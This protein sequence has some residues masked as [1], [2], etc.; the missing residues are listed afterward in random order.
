MFLVAFSGH[1]IAAKADPIPSQMTFTTTGSI[2]PTG[3]DGSPIVSFHGV[4]DGTLTTGTP[5]DL[6]TLVVTPPTSGAWPTYANA[7]LQ[8]N[9]TVDS[10]NGLPV[11]TGQASFTI[12]ALN[13]P[14][15]ST[16]L[17]F[18]VC[19][20]VAIVRRARRGA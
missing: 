16:L 11:A 6:G 7:P 19:S 13:T 8:I 1:A 4:T 17:I 15:P 20:T 14:E 12:D 18:L 2:G 3:I 9:V 5:F 10:V